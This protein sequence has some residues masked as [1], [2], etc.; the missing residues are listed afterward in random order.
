MVTMS[1]K[2]FVP[3]AAKSVSQALMSD[4]ADVKDD[5]IAEAASLTDR[6]DKPAHAVPRL[7]SAAIGRHEPVDATGNEDDLGA[8]SCIY[9]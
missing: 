4:S 6:P 9:P 8:A 3:Q 1:Q 5:G 7:R 2:S